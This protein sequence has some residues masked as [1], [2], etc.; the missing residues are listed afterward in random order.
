MPPKIDP[1]KK[2]PMKPPIKVRDVETTLTAF[3]SSDYAIQSSKTPYVTL[4]DFSDLEAA[5][6][7][8]NI[9]EYSRSNSIDP[10]VVI[11]HL[12]AIIIY[13]TLSNM[14]ITDIQNSK[15]NLSKN[16]KILVEKNIMRKEDLRNYILTKDKGRK[17]DD[18]VSIFKN[19]ND[20]INILKENIYT[21]KHAVD[22]PPSLSDLENSCSKK[23]K[24]EMD[25]NMKWAIDVLSINAHTDQNAL[26]GTNS[27][28]SKQKMTIQSP[29]SSKKDDNV[30]TKKVDDKKASTQEP[31]ARDKAVEGKAVEGKAIEVE[32]K[33]IERKAIEVERKAI[34]RKAIEVERKAIERKAIERKAI[35]RKAVEQNPVVNTEKNAAK[36]AFAPEKY[37]DEDEDLSKLATLWGL[38]KTSEKSNILPYPNEKSN[39]NNLI[40][41][42]EY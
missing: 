22:A 4:T 18:I 26:A 17:P 7:N 33:A 27:N 30:I 29:N 5:I 40:I 8:D 20:E 35:E 3:I 34:E 23:Q 39:I 12:G 38:N 31:D 42:C 14:S 19:L 16:V 24:I 13:A 32:R 15:L 36:A 25:N 2:R 41:A 37:E 11:A 21:T 10:S 28:L 1:Q 6:E 9:V